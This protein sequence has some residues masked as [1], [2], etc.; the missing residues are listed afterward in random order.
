MTNKVIG[1]AELLSRSIR[2]TADDR[3]AA[4]FFKVGIYIETIAM[5][6][7][8]G[9][10]EDEIRTVVEKERSRLINSHNE[11]EV[12]FLD[13]ALARVNQKVTLTG[14]NATEVKAYSELARVSAD[15]LEGVPI[16]ADR[17][18][19]VALRELGTILDTAEDHKVTELVSKKELQARAREELVSQIGENG[20]SVLRYLEPRMYDRPPTRD[21]TFLHAAAVSFSH[22]EEDDATATFQKLKD[23]GLITADRIDSYVLITAEG[24][25]A[26]RDAGIGS[27]L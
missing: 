9:L 21:D 19:V 17:S 3:I 10:S 15:L 14:K 24:V 11:A 1:E 22:I 20:I 5:A 6:R 12:E 8:N 27:E 13:A 7:T 25:K 16:V 26:L 23:K 2:S 4:P 18:L